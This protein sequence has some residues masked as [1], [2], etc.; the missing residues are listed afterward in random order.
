MKSPID[1]I[2]LLGTSTPSQ[3]VNTV[4]ELDLSALS[5]VILD[6]PFGLSERRTMCETYHTRTSQQN[7]FILID[8]ALCLYLALHQKEERLPLLLMSTLPFTTYQPF[9]RDGG[10]TSDEM[11]CGRITELRSIMDKNGA[12]VVYGGRQLGKT[13][14][15]ERAAKRCNVPEQKLF[16][17]YISIYDCDSEEKFVKK[18]VKEIN[19]KSFDSINIRETCTSI[20]VLCDEIEKLF[21]SEKVHE[22]KLFIDEADKFLNSI[23][24]GNY[25][26]LQPLIDLRRN[27]TNNF[28]FVLAGLHNVCRAQKAT[29]NNGVFGQLGQPLCVKPL[30][31]KDAIELISKPLRYLGFQIDRFPH[32]ETILTT[33]NY[34]PGILQFFGYTLV[35]TLT[36][37]YKSYY[38]AENNPPFPLQKEQLA[39]VINSTDLNESIKE[40]FKLSLKLDPRYF[41][42]ARCIAYR[43]HYENNNNRWM[44]YSIDEIK[45]VADSYPIHCLEGLT[46]IE[47]KNLLNEMV[48]MGILS[49]ENDSYR[50]RKASF[51]DV[52]GRDWDKV[53]EEILSDNG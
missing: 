31:P 6:K 1:V 34:Y 53:D 19:K 20:E 11:F 36:S 29:E 7:P 17:V 5:I 49:P 41:M 28:K 52:I 10:S 30:S 4:K 26:K 43:Y 48:E 8:Q 42:L 40:K 47:Y 24:N 21:N 35:E 9:V 50:L 38:Q 18:A 14:L 33:T 27:T 44:G 16:A 46:K 22:L 51:I 25:E 39:S 45:E 32:L 12:S 15:L 3:I 23:A 37:N 2:V 13:A